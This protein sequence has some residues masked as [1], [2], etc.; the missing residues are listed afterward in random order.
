MTIEV[1]TAILTRR[2]ARMRTY[3]CAAIFG[4]SVFVLGF[5]WIQHIIVSPYTQCKDLRQFSSKCPS[6][7]VSVFT[8]DAKTY[9]VAF[10]PWVFLNEFP[11]GFLFDDSGRMIGWSPEAGDVDKLNKYWTAARFGQ[12]SDSMPIKNVLGL[13]ERRE[14]RF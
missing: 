1:P 4:Y 13:I 14:L 5:L 7:T 9:I 6:S 11:S 12:N 3:I 8:L 10:G 2:K